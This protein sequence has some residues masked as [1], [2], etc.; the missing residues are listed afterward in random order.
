VS[1]SYNE[2]TTIERST[3]LGRAAKSAI[4][5]A[6]LQNR[7][8]VTKDDLLIGLLEAV[9]RFGIV[10]LGSW[11]IDLEA[12]INLDAREADAVRED[13]AIGSA[14]TDGGP[15]SKDRADSSVPKV[16]Y[17]A[18]AAAMFDQAAAVARSDGADRVEA[19]HML[20]AFAPDDEGIMG[21]L[22]STYGF[23]STEWRAALIDWEPPTRKPSPSGSNRPAPSGLSDANGRSHELRDKLLL[24]P[25]EAA[26]VLGVH[27]QTV[28]G[29]IRDGKLK[30]HRVAGE[31]AIRIRRED[32]LALL[33]PYDHDS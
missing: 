24:S 9:A 6:K 26:E 15:G 22:K 8:E 27:T 19:V 20:V 21:K 16:A 1:L 4:T 17:S 30:A 5:R 31:R 32:L 12:L 13:G 28:R 23:N 14:Q 33:E 18:G 7:P 29:Y 25:D 10:P 3:T 11:A 2:H